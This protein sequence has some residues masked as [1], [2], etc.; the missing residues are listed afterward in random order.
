MASAATKA[1]GTCLNRKSKEGR[2]PVRAMKSS[3]SQPGSGVSRRCDVARG[4]RE[5]RLRWKRK[6]HQALSKV[7]SDLAGC[8]TTSVRA[9]G[10]AIAGEITDSSRMPAKQ[11]SA[12]G[13][14]R[15]AIPP[16]CLKIRLIRELRFIGTSENRRSKLSPPLLGP[17]G[18]RGVRLYTHCGAPPDYRICLEATTRLLRGGNSA[19]HRFRWIIG[20]FRK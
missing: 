18:K 12:W 9:T 3:R 2:G 19:H 16:A 10:R 20:G 13:A 7:S 5:R 14:A 8:P 1:D 15:S 17:T 6:F 4:R 11:T